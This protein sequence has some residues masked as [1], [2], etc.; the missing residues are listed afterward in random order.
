MKKTIITLILLLITTQNAF[1]AKVPDNVKE[2]FKKEFAKTDFRFDGLVTLPDGT[3]YLP[4]YPALVKKPEKLEIKSTIPTG[5]TIKD[6][7]DVIILN[8]DFTLLKVI[9]DQKN[10][11]TVLNMKEPPIEVRTGLLPQD[12]LVPTGLVI[13]DNIK[14]I[15]GNLQIPTA[16]DFSYR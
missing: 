12:M 8:D 11:K 5:K 3:L 9:T 10:R 7:P 4:L 14:G 13:P 16:L 2:V 6:R 1:A 15:I